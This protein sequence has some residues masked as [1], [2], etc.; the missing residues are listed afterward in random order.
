MVAPTTE[1][2]GGYVLVCGGSYNFSIGK[3]EKY[4]NTYSSVNFGG[5]MKRVA[6]PY[7]HVINGKSNSQAA[8]LAFVP[9]TFEVPI[10]EV[11]AWLKN[12]QIENNVDLVLARVNQTNSKQLLHSLLNGAKRLTAEKAQVDEKN[13]ASALLNLK[14]SD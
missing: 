6:T 10:N 14:L 3:L 9:R 13:G 4:N 11:E 12:F 8:P 1:D 2:T 5:D 7:L